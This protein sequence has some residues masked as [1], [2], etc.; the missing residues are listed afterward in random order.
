MLSTTLATIASLIQLLAFGIYNQQ[1][2]TGA[3][4]PN[5][6]SW[7]IWAFIT[8]LN[9]TSYK[10]MSRDW[11]KALLPTV[12]SLACIATFA[13]TLFT[14]RVA[15][16]DRF[17]WTAFGIGLIAGLTW[18]KFRSATFANMII[19]VGLVIGFV[20]TL[21]G[22][23]A[24]HHAE[25]GFC[26][27]MWTFAYLMTGTVVILRWKRQP[28]DLVNPILCVIAHGAIAIVAFA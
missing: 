26:W 8:V 24:N 10:E 27:A 17:D 14:G 7:G 21:R 25:N 15:N 3:A 23:L 1:I 4:H 22:A 28:Q 18:Y 16:L 2:L 5:I 11:V 9:F 19:Q 20:P 6:A 13:I 12:D